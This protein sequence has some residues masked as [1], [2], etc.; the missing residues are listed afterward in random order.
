[1]FHPDLSAHPNLSV[2]QFSVLFLSAFLAGAINTVAG[3]GT[4][5]T[6]PILLFVGYNPIIAN[7]TSTVALIPASISGAWGYR[8]ELKE[9]KHALSRLLPISLIGGAL[10]AF[11]LVHTRPDTFKAIVP[12]LILGATCLFM[13]QEPISR[14]SKKRL[15]RNKL[16]TGTTLE[17]SIDAEVPALDR[18]S[19]SPLTWIGV[20][21]F[22]ML[23]AVYGGYFGAGA[24]ILMLAAYGFLGFTNIHRMN[25]L[26]NLNGIAINGIAALTFIFKGLVDWR[27]A[28]IMALGALTGGISG[29]KMARS[30]GQ[31]NVRLLVIAV[32]FALTLTLLIR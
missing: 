27:T 25:G 31:K 18:G 22:Q 29:V 13:V 26:K 17:S 23:V 15:E 12:Y 20:M 2:L 6:F 3:G 16:S 14:W 5:I 8:H 30:M 24:G 4:L 32:G 11:L 19:S 1:M 10:G 9:S 7:A 28:A 21:G